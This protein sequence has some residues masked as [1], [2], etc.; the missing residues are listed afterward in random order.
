LILF[1]GQFSFNRWVPL[2]EYEPLT[3]AKHLLTSLCRRKKGGVRVTKSLVSCA[4]F[5][6]PLFELT[7]CHFSFD[8]CIVCHSSIHRHWCPILHFRTF[9]PTYNYY[10]IRL[11]STSYC[12]IKQV[13]LPH[14]FKDQHKY[15]MWQILLLTIVKDKTLFYLWYQTLVATCNLIDSNLSLYYVCSLFTQLCD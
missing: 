15:I 14:H 13:F 12:I 8:Y 7:F 11:V 6:Q 9:L 1:T 3:L 10:V 4:M 2:V 5:R